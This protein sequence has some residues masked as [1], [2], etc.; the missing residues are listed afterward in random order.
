MSFFRKLFKKNNENNS[1]NSK[2]EEITEDLTN[3]VKPLVRAATKIVVMDSSIEPVNSQLKS[4]FGGK[5]YFEKSWEWPKNEGGKSL[6]FIFQIFNNGEINLPSQVKLIQFFYDWDEFPWETESSGWLIKVHENI[7]PLEIIEIARPNELEKT[8]YCEIQFKPFLSL[9]D[10]E[11][12]GL[13]SIESLNVSEKLNKKEPWEAYQSIVESLVGEQDYQSQIGG[14]PNWVQSEST[15][16]QI[17]GNPMKL[18][19]QIDS[20]EKAG[21]MWGDVGLIYLFYDEVTKKCEFTLQCH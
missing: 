18:L 21:I 16:K 14:Y 9:P 13:Y 7:N 3:L 15:P 20:E 4:H 10:W 12:L 1:L 5:P 11:G 6:D 2:Q 19:V 8:K 17:D